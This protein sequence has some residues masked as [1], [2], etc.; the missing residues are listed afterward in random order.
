MKIH[1]VHFA[2]LIF[3]FNYIVFQFIIELLPAMILS[4]S[5][6]VLLH[7]PLQYTILAVDI[8]GKPTPPCDP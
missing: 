2:S 4:A 5:S 1:V 8:A 7:L 3:L 6:T